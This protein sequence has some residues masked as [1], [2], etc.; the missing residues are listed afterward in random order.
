[1]GFEWEG[2]GTLSYL[3]SSSSVA[4]PVAVR[5]AWAMNPSC[6]LYDRAGLPAAP[7]RADDWDDLLYVR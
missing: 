5:Y 1:M 6:N 3:V 4:H 7:F 2:S